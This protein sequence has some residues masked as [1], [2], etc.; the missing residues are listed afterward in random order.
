MVQAGLIPPGVEG[1]DCNP[2]GG[3]AIAGT[4]RFPAV[5]ANPDR[6]AVGVEDHADSMG[7]PFGFQ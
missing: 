3:M 6:C 1:I 4:D 5:V 7:I 2:A